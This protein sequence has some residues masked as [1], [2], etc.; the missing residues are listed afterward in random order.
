MNRIF[1]IVAAVAF[2]ASGAQ[3]MTVDLSQGMTET[4]DPIVLAEQKN[5]VVKSGEV[6]VDFLVG[7]NVNVGDTFGGVNNYVGAIGL[8]AGVYDSFLI[9]FDPEGTPKKPVSGS[10]TFDFVGKI[11]ALIV[12]NGSGISKAAQLLNES[13]ALFGLPSWTY[14]SNLG[15]RTETNDMMTLVDANTLAVEFETRNQYIDNIRVITQAAAVPLPASLPLL[16]AGFGGLA[17]MRRK[18]RAA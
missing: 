7:T 5:L 12:S 3:A 1:S 2:A 16:L 6:D 18:R 15:R 10:A 11:V 9:H 4:A 13:D 14:E 8:E 17:A